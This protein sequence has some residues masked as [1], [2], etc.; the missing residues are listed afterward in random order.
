MLNR[1]ARDVYTPPWGSID[2]AGRRRR[3]QAFAVRWGLRL[4]ALAVFVAAGR[5]AL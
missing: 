5:L 1:P 4:A 3:A 2:R